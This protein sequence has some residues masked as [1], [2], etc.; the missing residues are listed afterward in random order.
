MTGELRRTSADVLLHN[1]DDESEYLLP[2]RTE[3]KL[4]VA[5][6]G[7]VRVRLQTVVP[8]A[9]TAAA[10]GAPLPPGRWEVHIAPTVAGFRRIA[11]VLRKG[12]PLV[13]TTYAP[14]RIVVGDGPPP[15]PGA[16][17]RTY[18]RLPWPAI[19]TLKRARAVAGRSG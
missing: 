6:N 7:R 5:E 13:L 17:V 19:R 2:A 12:E 8:I 3:A 16:A 9:P 4:Q 15:A 18:R 1:V 11:P 10:A 14:G